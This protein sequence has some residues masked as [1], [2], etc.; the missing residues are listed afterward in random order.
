MERKRA[1]QADEY[2]LV[3]ARARDRPKARSGR[4]AGVFQDVPHGQERYPVPE[5]GGLA[6]NALVSPARIFGSEPQH[7]LTYSRTV[8][9][10]CGFR[11]G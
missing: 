9:G 6:M 8:G 5:L 1:H 3:I 4:K 11:I 2:I 7:Q 10:R